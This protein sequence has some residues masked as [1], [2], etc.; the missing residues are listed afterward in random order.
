MVV[1]LKILT[2]ESPFYGKKENWEPFNYLSKGMW[3]HIKNPGKKRVH[4]EA[5]F[6]SAHP[7]VRRGRKTELCTEKDA[8]AEWRGT[9]R[10]VSTSSNIDKPSFL[11]SNWSQGNAG[12][13]FMSSRGTGIRG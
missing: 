11:L 3:H 2:R 7:S 8:P 5:S 10:K 13:H 1:R 6:K 9:W 4:R 12:A